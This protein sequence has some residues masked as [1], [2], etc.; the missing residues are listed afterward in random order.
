MT[1]FLKEHFRYFIGRATGWN[2]PT[3]YANNMKIHTIGLTLQQQDTLF[4]LLD[5]PE[6]MDEINELIFQFN[7]DHGFSWQACWNGRS[8]GYLVL[9]KGG[10]RE[11]GHKSFCTACGQRNFTSVEETG[12]RCGR[13]GQEKRVNFQTPPRQSY[14]RFE[15]VDQDEDYEFFSM[16]ELKARIKLVQEFDR[17]CDEII[18]E[19]AYLADHFRV[20]E[21]EIMIPSTRKVMVEI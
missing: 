5:C 16:K 15:A 2:P 11:T 7:H 3:G 4:D 13:C 21:E 19:A 6:A 1:Q 10:Q 9:V 8:G 14:I 18:Q 12:C 20:E 17:L